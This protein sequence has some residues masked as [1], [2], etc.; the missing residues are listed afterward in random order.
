MEEGFLV[1]SCFKLVVLFL[2]TLGSGEM[3]KTGVP[4]PKPNDPLALPSCCCVGM[5]ARLAESSGCLKE[6]RNLNFFQGGISQFFSVVKSFKD[7]KD[8]EK[9]RT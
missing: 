7:V 5:W 6:A 1:V 8:I 9:N 3:A 4:H 2:R